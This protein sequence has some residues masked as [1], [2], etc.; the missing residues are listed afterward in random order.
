MLSNLADSIFA[1]GKS[2][3]GESIR[4]IKQVKA[5]SSEKVYDSE[6]VGTFEIVKDSNFLQFEFRGLDNESVH[7]SNPKRKSKE[8]EIN[9]VLRL[10]SQ[11]KNQ[12]EISKCLNMSLGKVNKI[13]NENV[14]FYDVNNMNILNKN[15]EMP[16]E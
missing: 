9:E 12:R 11:G 16:I 6:N 2:Q 3:I 1:I 10:K 4:Y 15:K 7:L 13:I 8:E 14:H 5:R